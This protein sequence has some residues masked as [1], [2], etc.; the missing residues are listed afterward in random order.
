MKSEIT[1]ENRAKFFAQHWGQMVK[2][3]NND[4]DN[5]GLVGVI[6]MSKPYLPNFHL[7]LSPLSSITDED[8]FVCAEIRGHDISKLTALEAKGLALIRFPHHTDI[9]FLLLDYLRSKGYALPWMG[10]SVE[11]LINAGWIRLNQ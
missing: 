4:Y 11:E 1:L 2:C 10:L 6:F 3:W 8:A 5:V 7:K 9:S